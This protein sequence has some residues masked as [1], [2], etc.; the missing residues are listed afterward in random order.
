MKI[1][2]RVA[3][4]LVAVYMAIF[5]ITWFRFDPRLV[6]TRQRSQIAMGAS[7]TDVLS[8]FK[9]SPPFDIPEADYCENGVKVSRIALL[10]D[11]GFWFF[12]L[13]LTLPTTTTFC[14]D[15]QDHLVGLKA[16][17]W[18]DAP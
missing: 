5:A 14:F 16:K 6:E 3:L 7:S 15:A 2:G 13:P 11:G 8:A 4:A 18:V 12:P 1:L 17:R 10:E 9:A